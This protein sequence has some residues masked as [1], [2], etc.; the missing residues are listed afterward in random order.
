[1]GRESNWLSGVTTEELLAEC[2]RRAEWQA[3][4]HRRSAPAAGREFSLS[5]TALEE[6]GWRWR[7]G[8]AALRDA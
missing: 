8:S 6:A 1:M 7:R 3:A 5:R 2:E 4:H